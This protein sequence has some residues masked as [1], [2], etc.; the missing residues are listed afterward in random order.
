MANSRCTKWIIVIS[1]K[2]A[3]PN[4]FQW[5]GNNS[6]KFNFN[7][8]KYQHLNKFNNNHIVIEFSN[9]CYNKHSWWSSNN[10]KYQDKATLMWY[11][12]W[13]CIQNQNEITIKYVLTQL[14]RY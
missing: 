3:N 9:K 7:K 2:Q 12:R 4:N 14:I 8:N 5:K 1:I 11:L 6:S 10:S 13:I